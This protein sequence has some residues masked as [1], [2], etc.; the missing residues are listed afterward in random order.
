[1]GKPGRETLAEFVSMFAEVKKKTGANIYLTYY[2]MAAHPGC[3]QSHM[4][5]LHTFVSRRLKL[6]PE[7]VQIFTPSPST[8]ATLMYL[9]ERDPFTERK[10]FVEKSIAGKQKQKVTLTGPRTQAWRKK[11]G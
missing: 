7:Q 11:S 6:L 4:N 10:I 5:A 9:T 2:L 8:M 3:T 1:M